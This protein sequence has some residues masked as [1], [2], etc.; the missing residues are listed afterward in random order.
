M[1]RA[2]NSVLG[3]N[4]RVF[5]GIWGYALPS[6]MEKYCWRI[7]GVPPSPFT[8][9]IHQTSFKM[10]PII[11]FNKDSNFEIAGLSERERHLLMS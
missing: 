9:K 11:G 7:W 10:L 8:E 3:P 2:K 1:K 4:I 6:F 5:G